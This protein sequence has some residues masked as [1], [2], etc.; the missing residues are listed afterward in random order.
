MSDI[1][2][3]LSNEKRQQYLDEIEYIQ[4]KVRH[5]ITPNTKQDWENLL[6]YRK[7][8]LAEDDLHL[9]MKLHGL[10]D[11][12]FKKDLDKFLDLMCQYEKT[13]RRIEL[14]NKKLKQYL[15][16]VRSPDIGN[17]LRIPSSCFPCSE[18]DSNNLHVEL[19]PL[20]KIPL[21]ENPPLP[22]INWCLPQP[23]DDPDDLYA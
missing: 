4:E 1:K 10:K 15:C 7:M 20:P 16:R 23:G 12:L 22:H 8:I 9:N 2:N 19:M 14:Q 18:N 17:T 21:V 6:I 13:P 5:Q 3:V 11:E